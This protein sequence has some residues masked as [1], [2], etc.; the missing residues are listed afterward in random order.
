V[1]RIFAATISAALIATPLLA[2]AENKMEL[3]TA[4][5]GSVAV[6]AAVATPELSRSPGAPE[7]TLS[8]EDLAKKLSK[9]ASPAPAYSLPQRG[10]RGQ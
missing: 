8:P 6:E 2:R 7:E 10:D 5:V 4:T 1:S 3:R 9:A